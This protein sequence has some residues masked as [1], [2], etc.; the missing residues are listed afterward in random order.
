[1]MNKND[2]DDDDES[3]ST[4][5]QYGTFVTIKGTSKYASKTNSILIQLSLQFTTSSVIVMSKESMN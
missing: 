4:L 5:T 1:M 2:A 3:Y